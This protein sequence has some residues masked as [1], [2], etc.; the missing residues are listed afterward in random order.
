MGMLKPYST[1]AVGM[2]IGY[3][4]LGKVI[5]MLPIGTGGA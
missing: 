1:L 4:L 3:F 5:K 2:L